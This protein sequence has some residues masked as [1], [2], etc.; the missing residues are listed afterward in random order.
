MIVA[1]FKL[2]G[3]YK[4]IIEGGHNRGPNLGSR[5]WP[6]WEGPSLCDARSPPASLLAIAIVGVLA[7]GAFRMDPCRPQSRPSALGRRRWPFADLAHYG[8]A[9]LS[10][11]RAL[12]QLGPWQKDRDIATSVAITQRATPAY[13]ASKRRLGTPESGILRGNPGKVVTA[14]LLDATTPP[15]NP[16]RSGTLTH[17]TPAILCDRM[18]TKKLSWYAMFKLEG[19]TAS[20]RPD[21]WVWL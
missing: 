5:S 12:Q 6:I 17:A 14:V 10:P 13:A 1:L 18:A 9:A 2:A 19:L 21:I 3:K 11:Q 20:S 7:L 8:P 16:L 15:T 4:S